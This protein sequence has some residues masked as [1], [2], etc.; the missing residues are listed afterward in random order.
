MELKNKKFV[1][2]IHQIFEDLEL[3]YP[4]IRLREAGAEVV[5]A[6]EKAGNQYTGKNGVPATADIGYDDLDVNE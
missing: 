1:A 4:V 2:I 5:L 3:W 6:G